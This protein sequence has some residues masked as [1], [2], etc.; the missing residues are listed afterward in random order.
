[1]TYILQVTEFYLCNSGNTNKKVSAKQ[2]FQWEKW[3]MMFSAKQVKSLHYERNIVDGW[4]WRKYISVYFKY[5]QHILVHTNGYI[6]RKFQYVWNNLDFPKL[7]ILIKVSD[8]N[9][10]W[11][12]S[13][14]S[15]LKSI[16]ILLTPCI[17]WFEGV[18]LLNHSW[19]NLLEMIWITEYKMQ[20][21]W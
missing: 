12:H 10:W 17:R 1:M 6:G 18:I 14:G 19:N 9:T 16:A 4:T 8:K 11:K 5:H 3:E 15:V 21:M 7:L 20:Q 2:L 13:E